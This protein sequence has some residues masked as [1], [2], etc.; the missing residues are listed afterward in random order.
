MSKILTTSDI[1]SIGEIGEVVWLECYFDGHTSLQPYMFDIDLTQ[2]PTM[3][4]ARDEFYNNWE[5]DVREHITNC[6]GTSWRDKR[7]RWWDSKPT[8]EERNNCSKWYYI[9]AAPI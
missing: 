6:F 4:N 2:K 1:C 8:D 5:N 7:Y 3:T 9:L